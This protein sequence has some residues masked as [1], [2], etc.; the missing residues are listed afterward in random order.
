MSSEARNER[1]DD[2]QELKEAAERLRRAQEQYD[3]FVNIT[4]LDQKDAPLHALDRM[5]VA[6]EEL[7]DATKAFHQLYLRRL[8]TDPDFAKRSADAE[9]RLSKGPPWDDKFSPTELLKESGQP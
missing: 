5:R 8:K 3:H 7:D 2:R 6:Q 9:A 1:A 4:P